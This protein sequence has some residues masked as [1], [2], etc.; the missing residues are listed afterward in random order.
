MDPT[1]LYTHDLVFAKEASEE[2][3]VPQAVLRKWASR[4]DIRRYPGDPKR[5]AGE[6]HEYK[7]MYALPEVKARAERYKSCPQRRPKAA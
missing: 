6:G 4:G 7:T 5:Y 2:T 1:E 3:G